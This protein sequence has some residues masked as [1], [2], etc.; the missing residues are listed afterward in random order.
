[1]NVKGWIVMAGAVAALA[2]AAHAEGP[3]PL[4]SFERFDL[5][6]GTANGLWA[7]LGSTYV[8][9]TDATDLATLFGVLA[10]G[11]GDWAEAGLILPYSLVEESDD[12]IGDL[13]LYGKLVPVRTRLLDVGAGFEFLFPTGDQDDGLGNDEFGFLPYVTG[14]LHVGPAELRGHGGYRFYDDSDDANGR[15]PLPESWVYGGALHVPLGDMLTLRLETVGE[16]IDIPGEDADL[17]FFQ[18]G[19]DVQLALDGAAVL[20]RP[21]LA[22]GVNDDTPDWGIGGSVVLLWAGE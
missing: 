19:V 15:N 13:R 20:L 4:R 18:P 5:D 8:E 7:E 16:T 12:G 9:D 2:A 21:T 3:V 11:D 10:Y 14:A 17:V 22:V 6:S 1:M